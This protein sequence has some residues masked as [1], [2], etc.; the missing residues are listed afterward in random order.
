MFRAY[1]A[2]KKYGV[3]LDE[4]KSGASKQLVSVRLIAEYLSG[5]STRRS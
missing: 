4:I 3:V 1:I 2:Q 5:D